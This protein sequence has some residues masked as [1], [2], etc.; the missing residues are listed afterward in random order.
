MALSSS[1]NKRS[2]YKRK[3]PQIIQISE[4][5][6]LGLDFI[7]SISELYDE[8]ESLLRCP[9]VIVK[10]STTILDYSELSSIGKTKSNS[11]SIEDDIYKIKVFFEATVSVGDTITLSDGEYLNELIDPDLYDIGG[12]Y[13]VVSFDVNNF[14]IVLQTISANN[15]SPTY[16][17]YD[18]KYFVN[19]S[20]K[21]TTTEIKKPKLT[22]TINEIVNR[23]GYNS[24]NSF[25]SVLGIPK[26]K[27]ILEI[28]IDSDTTLSFTVNEYYK[29]S[30]SIEHLVVNE[31]VPDDNIDLFS[32]NIFV[33][34][35]RREEIKKKVKKVRKVSPDMMHQMSNGKWMIGNTHSEGNKILD[36]LKEID[37]L[38]RAIDDSSTYTPPVTRT[39]TRTSTPSVTRTTTRTSTPSTPSTYTP[40]P[41]VGGGMD[42]GY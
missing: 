29:D 13:K 38:N 4:G 30:N 19:G 7:S 8:E 15:P 32:N 3:I 20:L 34:L 35:K 28:Q 40:P 26:K 36:A 1:K 2:K 17:F 22:E 18:K 11:Q 27:D 14:I 33:V 42:G 39:T 5:Y 10:G 25:R 31:T 24:K 6:L 37:V 9:N 12:S 16:N 41:S 21:W 23:I